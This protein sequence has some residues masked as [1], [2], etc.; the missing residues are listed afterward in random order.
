[1]ATLP[2]VRIA[3]LIPAGP[4]DDALDTLA[5][6]VPIPIRPGSSWSFTTPESSPPGTTRSPASHPTLSSCQAVPAPGPR[7]SRPLAIHDRLQW[8]AGP[9]G[10][11]SQGGGDAGF[12]GQPQD[13]DGQVACSLNNEDNLAVQEAVQPGRRTAAMPGKSSLAGP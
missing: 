3:V 8:P 11:M 1:M 9:A 4:P 10:V 12:L 6:V 2:S 5:S 7:Q 13:G